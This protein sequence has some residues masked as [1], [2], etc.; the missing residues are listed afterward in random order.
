MNRRTAQFVKSLCI[1]DIED[2]MKSDL[3]V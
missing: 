3:A 2:S 1:I